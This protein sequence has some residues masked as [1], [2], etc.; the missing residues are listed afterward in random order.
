MSE[1][2][3]VTLSPEIVSKASPDSPVITHKAVA[4]LSSKDI[5]E[6]NIVTEIDEQDAKE[7]PTV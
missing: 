4:G 3:K 1:T 5:I 6:R 2:I 7:Q